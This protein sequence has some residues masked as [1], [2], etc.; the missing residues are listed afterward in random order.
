MKRAIL[1]HIQSHFQSMLDDCWTIAIVTATT[2]LMRHPIAGVRW[3]WNERKWWRK[4]SDIQNMMDYII[5][6]VWNFNVWI[7]GIF[8]EKAIYHFWLF[9]QINETVGIH[10]EKKTLE[11]TS[12]Q[13]VWSFQYVF[14]GLSLMAA[15]D[16]VIAIHIIY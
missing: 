5:I 4:I 1:W 16:F 12:I 3:K 8:I 14:Y 13:H 10:R 9:L 11:K 2:A 15:F 6:R 7:Y